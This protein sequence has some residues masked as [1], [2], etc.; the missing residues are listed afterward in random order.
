MDVE[1]KRQQEQETVAE[2]IAIYCRA[3]HGRREGLCPQCESLARYAEARIAACPRMAVK[4]FCSVCP[5][6]CYAPARRQ[7]I[8]AVMRYGGPRMLLHHPL[9]TL[10]HM[11]L[12]WQTRLGRVAFFRHWRQSDRS[13]KAK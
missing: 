10:R 12:G 4:S 13:V 2:I 5:V 3:H 8:Q 9:M 7:E 1:K 11:M 6:H